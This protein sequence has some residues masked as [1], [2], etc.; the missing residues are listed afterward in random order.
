MIHTRPYSPDDKAAWD[1][2]VSESRNGTFMLYRDFMEYHADRFQDQSL[3]VYDDD[4]LIAVLPGSR[5]GEH[6]RSH[7]GLTYA[8]FVA[9]RDFRAD[10][11]LKAVAAVINHLKST[12]AQSMMLKPVPHIYHRMPSEEELYA[13]HRHGAVLFRRDISSTIPIADR[14]SFSKGRKWTINK[15]RK[16]GVVVAPSDNWEAFMAIEE[17]LLMEKRGVK[18][19]HSAAEMRY[20]A[21]LFPKNIEL[22]LATLND[23]ILAGVVTFRSS[24]VLHAQYIGSI[25]KG[26]MIGA[27][28]AIIDHLL[29]QQ[30]QSHRFFDFGISTTDEGRMLD[31]AL[32]ANKES[33]GARGTSYDHYRIEFK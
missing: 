3:L 18:P 15:S 30:C 20:L 9:S 29:T 5:H 19:V 1:R 7:G 16:E 12:G 22:W 2:C 17:A 14:Y 31:E 6:W 10:N 27:V 24:M 25:E 11:A 4:T 28:D 33:Y 13:L 23:E 21:G 32:V 26:R 8:G